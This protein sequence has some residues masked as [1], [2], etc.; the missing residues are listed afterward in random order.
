MLSVFRRSLSLGQP[1]GLGLAVE[2]FRN[3]FRAFARL[4]QTSPCGTVWTGGFFAIRDLL[5]SNLDTSSVSL[6]ATTAGR[7]PVGV[8]VEDD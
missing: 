3:P 8:I 2:L 6:A 5:V 4:A 1:P 7:L